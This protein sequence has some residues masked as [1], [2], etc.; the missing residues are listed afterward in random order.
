MREHN[1]TMPQLGMIALTRAMMGAG[2]GMLIADRIDEK[3]R[4]AIAIPLVALGAL[5][6]VPLAISVMRDHRHEDREEPYHD[7]PFVGLE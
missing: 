5:S 3:K 4:K 1:V 2:I 6:T 7:E